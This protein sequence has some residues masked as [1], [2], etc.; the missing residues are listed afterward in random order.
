MSTIWKDTLNF[1]TLSALCGWEGAFACP[2]L[3]QDKSQ[4]MVK[5][6]FPSPLAKMYHNQGLTLDLKT[7]G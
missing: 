1:S 3:T 6:Q 2:H 5:L 4:G 7:S